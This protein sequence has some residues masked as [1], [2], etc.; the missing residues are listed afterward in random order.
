MCWGCVGGKGKLGVML[1]LGWEGGWWVV[2]GGAVRSGGGAWR[3]VGVVLV[4][5]SIG[6]GI[7]IGIGITI[8]K[9]T[10]SKVSRNTT[11]DF[12]SS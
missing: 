1:G 10:V 12:L 8:E 6:I 3:G 2:G 4:F 5:I 11:P 7:G 9:E